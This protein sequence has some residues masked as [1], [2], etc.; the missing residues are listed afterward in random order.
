MRVYFVFFDPNH[1]DTIVF[2]DRSAAARFER[3]SGLTM[4]TITD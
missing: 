2:V 1:N 4:Q 3:E